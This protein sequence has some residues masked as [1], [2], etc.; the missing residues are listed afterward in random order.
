[1]AYLVTAPTNFEKINGWI[2]DLNAPDAL[3]T[4]PALFMTS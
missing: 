4:S 3:V 1:M 2:I